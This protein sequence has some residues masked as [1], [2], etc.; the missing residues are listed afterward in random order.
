MEGILSMYSINSHLKFIIMNLMM[1]ILYNNGLIPHI[2]CFCYV[3]CGSEY[4]RHIATVSKKLSS[5]IY[6]YSL[7]F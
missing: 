4:L 3:T 5:L 7:G 6:S 1:I 2:N